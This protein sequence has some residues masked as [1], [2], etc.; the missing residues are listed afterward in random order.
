MGGGGAG[1]G[2]GGRGMSWAAPTSNVYKSWEI[3][4]QTALRK[5][6]WQEISP[7]ASPIP[8][9]PPA[10]PRCSEP[11]DLRGLELLQAPPENVF[12]SSY[13]GKELPTFL[14]FQT[15][16]IWCALFFPVC[17]ITRGLLTLLY[18]RCID[19]LLNI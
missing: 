18:M 6:L 17:G 16:P 11:K 8:L 12:F 15:H 7:P 4:S 3:S 9:V 1:G 13:P 2:G 19:R 14:C 5:S 10:P